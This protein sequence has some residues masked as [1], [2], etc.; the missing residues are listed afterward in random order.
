MNAGSGSKPGDQSRHSWSISAKSFIGTTAFASAAQYG[1]LI[2]DQAP[3]FYLAMM[4]S[5][6]ENE[7]VA[8][9]KDVVTRHAF[10]IITPAELRDELVAAF[11]QQADTVMALW[12]R[13][14]GPLGCSAAR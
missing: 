6:G 7:T 12:D 11:P 2:Y 3:G 13:Y 1:A 9:L 10:G 5:V 8:A 14:I 4:S